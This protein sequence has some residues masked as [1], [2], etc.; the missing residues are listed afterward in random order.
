MPVPRPLQ[1]LAQEL[2][3]FIVRLVSDGLVRGGGHGAHVAGRL[4][5]KN[6]AVSLGFRKCAKHAIG[7]CF[8][9][10]IVGVA[11]AP[12]TLEVA[13]CCADDCL[14]DGSEG[15][16]SAIAVVIALR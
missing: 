9:V 4:A 10:V 2:C 1:K 16:S 13:W 12:N 14:Q 6:G 3:E 7:R 5:T 11:A 8:I 15:L